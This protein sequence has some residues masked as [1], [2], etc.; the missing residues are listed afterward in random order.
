M[1]QPPSGG[2][3]LEGDETPG[4]LVQESLDPSVTQVT[5]NAPPGLEE[6]NP[7]SDSKT[8]LALEER[9]R[10]ALRRCPSDVN[11]H[12]FTAL[13]APQ[14]NEALYASLHSGIPQPQPAKVKMP[15]TAP[16]TQ[17]AIMKPTEE[18]PAY[19]QIA[20][21]GRQSTHVSEL[22]REDKKRTSSDDDRR[23]RTGP[24]AGPP[25]GYI[26]GLSTALQNAVDK[27]LMPE[28]AITQAELLKR[29][30]ELEK[31]AAE[32]DR[33][34]REIQSLNQPGGEYNI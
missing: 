23:R 32:L 11:G 18:P 22:Q 17:P 8:F 13:V 9:S 1:S 5:R 14:G 4:A 28:H 20:K 12:V 24:A 3:V 6:Y 21:V 2:D 26:R 16:S 7:F 19:T 33:R 30:E 25:L 31:K 15:T 29:Q 27:P 10:P 34:E